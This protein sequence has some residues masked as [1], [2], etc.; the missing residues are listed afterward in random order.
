MSILQCNSMHI[1][2][3]VP[4]VWH[5]KFRIVM[6]TESSQSCDVLDAC[7]MFSKLIC[8][9]FVFF[10]S[11]VKSFNYKQCVKGVS[12]FPITWCLWKFLTDFHLLLRM[13]GTVYCRCCCWWFWQ[14]GEN[15]NSFQTTDSKRVKIICAIERLCKTRFWLL[16]TFSPILNYTIPL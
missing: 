16:P 4:T 1:Y 11:W 2:V 14:Y 6:F 15:E 10:L 3:V 12:F 8:V 7:Q 13:A 5:H 9:T